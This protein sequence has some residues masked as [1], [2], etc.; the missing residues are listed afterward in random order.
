MAAR[1]RLNT[2]KSCTAL[3]IE[4]NSAGHA[5]QRSRSQR[6]SHNSATALQ[7]A[8]RV[9]GMIRRPSKNTVETIEALTSAPQNVA[10]STDVPSLSN[11]NASTQ[12]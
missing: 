11:R 10:T 3:T 5:G 8:D 2:W 12:N 4:A 1:V 6:L 7:T 9:P